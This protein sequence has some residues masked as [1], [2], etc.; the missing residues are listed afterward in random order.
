MPRIVEVDPQ[1][2]PRWVE[3]FEQRHGAAQPT[4]HADSL[5]LAAADGAIAEVLPWSGEPAGTV[6]RNR[7]V[8]VDDL[9]RWAEPPGRMGL[10]LVRRG[11]YAVGLG[12]R[13]RL[14][15]HHCGTR[16]VQSRTAAGG[17][18]QHRYARRRGNQADALVGSVVTRVQDIL[19]EIPLDALVVGG[20][21][22]LVRQVLEDPG[23][24]ALGALPRRELYDLPDPRLVVLHKALCRGRAVRITLVEP[25]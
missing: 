4:L 20:D 24:R 10:I 1:R 25:D 17:W 19:G 14:L 21:K 9:L 7:P 13:E 5:R 23:A 12:E 2:L 22:S 3:N 11:G 6:P 16:Y 15:R 8:V 18:S